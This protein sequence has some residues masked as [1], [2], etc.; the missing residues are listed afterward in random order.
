MPRYKVV[1]SRTFVNASLA[2]IGEI[3]EYDG[4]P[5]STLEPADDVA[6]RVKDAYD[7]MRKRGRT[8]PAG[9]PDLSKYQAAPVRAPAPEKEHTD[10]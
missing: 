6:A 9:K 10:E 5:G 8:I 1:T 3:I 2:E 7:T 4:W